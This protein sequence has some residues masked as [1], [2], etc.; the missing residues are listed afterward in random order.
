[1]TPTRFAFL[2]DLHG[3]HP[4]RWPLRERAAA[5][6]LLNASAEAKRLLIDARR[7]DA[8]LRHCGVAVEDAAVH[9]VLSTLPDALRRPRSPLKMALWSWG[10]LPLQ[11]RLG[12]VAASLI[13]GLIVGLAVDERSTAHQT[14]GSAIT[15]LVI[16][17]D[18]E[19]EWWL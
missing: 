9:R 1:M 5:E 2:L 8:A 6:S 17:T 11:P 12:L 10:L 14:S 13:L 19:G 4:E 16:G 18:P 15:F 7:L 3:P